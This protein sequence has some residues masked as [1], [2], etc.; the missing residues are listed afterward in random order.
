MG[1][2]QSKGLQQQGKKIVNQVLDQAQK[3]ISKTA[4]DI[5]PSTSKYETP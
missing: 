4:G 1:S 2:D 5:F 3:N